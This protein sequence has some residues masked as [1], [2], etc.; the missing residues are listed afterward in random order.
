MTDTAL[1]DVPVALIAL[2]QWPGEIKVIG[3]IS[4]QQGMACAFPKSSPNLRRAFN[5]FFIQCKN[6]PVS[7]FERIGDAFLP[8]PGTSILITRK[9]I[10]NFPLQILASIPEFEIYGS[11]S[12]WQILVGMGSLAV[13]IL[14][15]LGVLINFNS[16]HL[17]LV[18]RFDESKR[19]H[20]L[21]ASKNQQLEMEIFRRQEAGKVEVTRVD[22]NE[23]VRSGIGILETQFKSHGVHLEQDLA[24]C[25]MPIEFNDIIERVCQTRQQDSQ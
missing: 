17:I 10:P 11:M 8:A 7:G 13:V 18:T 5:E 24:V 19:Q 1:M 12:P 23:V 3:P 22:L 25:P 15:G 20:D 21:L 2:E 14:L 6:L 4:L 9:L 16:R